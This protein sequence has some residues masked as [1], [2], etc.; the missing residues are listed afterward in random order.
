VISIKS[1]LAAMR[2]DECS[3]WMRIDECS[4]FIL[5]VYFNHEVPPSPSNVRVVLP[6]P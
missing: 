3:S 1:D 6:L 4:D 2:I 5:G